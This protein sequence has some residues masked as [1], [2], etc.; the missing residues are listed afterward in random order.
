MRPEAVSF[1]RN[2]IDRDSRALMREMQQ[3]PL[4]WWQPY[5]AW[6]GHKLQRAMRVNGFA[7]EAENY[8]AVVE[9]AVRELED[10]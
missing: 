10:A 8:V 1:V 2:Y 9:T 3:R 7:T 6:W 4:T 5:E